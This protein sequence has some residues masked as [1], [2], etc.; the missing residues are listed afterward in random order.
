MKLLEKSPIYFD[1]ETYVPSMKLTIEVNVESLADAIAVLPEQELAQVVGL[2]FISIFKK[3][4]NEVRQN[5]T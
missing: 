1:P 5:F 3:A 2:E 4:R